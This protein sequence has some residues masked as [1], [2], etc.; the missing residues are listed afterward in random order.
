MAIGDDVKKAHKALAGAAGKLSLMLARKRINP[1]ELAH[2][3]LLAQ[4]GAV[5][6]ARLRDGLPVP[7]T[8]SEPEDTTC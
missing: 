3:A 7:T 2:A 4:E 5:T 8:N 1:G 6:L